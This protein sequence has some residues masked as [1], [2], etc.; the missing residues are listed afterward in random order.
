[1][2]RWGWVLWVVALYVAANVAWGL[3]RP[4]LIP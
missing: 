3:V 4:L 2:R 1:M